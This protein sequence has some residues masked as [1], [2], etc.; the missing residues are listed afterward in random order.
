MVVR[1]HPREPVFIMRICLISTLILVAALA[2]GGCNKGDSSPTTASAQAT[3]EVLGCSHDVKSN[4]VAKHSWPYPADF[5]NIRWGSTY[6]QMK[7]KLKP[8]H[9]AFITATVTWKKGELIGVEDSEVFVKKPRRLVAKR[10]L[11]VKRKVWDQGIEVE[12]TYLAVT[13]GAVGSF[14]F[15]NSRGM[16]MV[17]TEHG[18]GWTPCTLDDAFEGLSEERSAACEQVWWVKVRKGRVD[19]GWMPVDPGLME[20]VAPPTDV[21][22]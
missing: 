8:T 3:A 14:L 9:A 15:Y 5:R 6:Q 21:A 11:Y 16:C 4:A 2:T 7:L 10:D 20:R 12:R 19:Q 1:I 22:K 13:Q 17:G 18:P